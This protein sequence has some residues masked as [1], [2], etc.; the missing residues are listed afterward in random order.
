MSDEIA[1][2]ERIAELETALQDEYDALTEMRELRQRVRISDDRIRKVITA[3]TENEHRIGDARGMAE[4]CVIL[5]DTVSRIRLIVS[6][7]T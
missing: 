4:Q 5:M 6:D 1:L 3:L 7:C 2:R